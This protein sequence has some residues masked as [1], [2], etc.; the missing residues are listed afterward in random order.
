MSL[1]ST[2]YKGMFDCGAKIAWSTY[3]FVRRGC[4]C[5]FGMVPVDHPG[6]AVTLL[7]KLPHTFVYNHSKISVMP[8]CNNALP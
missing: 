5:W 2:A 1:S 6:S 8:R 7:V 4:V 3:N